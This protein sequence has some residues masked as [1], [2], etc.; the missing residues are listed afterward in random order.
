MARHYPLNYR[1]EY[2]PIAVAYLEYAEVYKDAITIILADFSGQ[3]PMHD[4]S[5]IPVLALLR[6]YIE[7][8]LKGIIMYC[9]NREGVQR[10]PKLPEGNG[11]R[12]APSS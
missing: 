1:P 7:L 9:E 11:G 12:R 5:L 6:Q 8:Q 2:L 4:Y 10:V 3:E